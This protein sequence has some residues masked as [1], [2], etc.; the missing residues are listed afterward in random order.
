[1]QKEPAAKIL[2]SRFFWFQTYC[3]RRSF[4]RDEVIVDRLA[5]GDEI[6]L[7]VGRMLPEQFQRRLRVGLLNVRAVE[8]VDEF[9][10]G[11][12][13][14]VRERRKK[15]GD[16]TRCSSQRAIA[17]PEIIARVNIKAVK[18]RVARGIGVR[19]LLMAPL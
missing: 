10:A 17:Q 12:R 5:A 15:R 6:D 9:L 18:V 3:S 13:S 7:R 11:L 1:M 14:L 8:D 2:C 16:L 19:P 4:R